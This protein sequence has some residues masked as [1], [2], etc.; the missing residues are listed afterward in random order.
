M[1][2]PIS[3][4][5]AESNQ[6]NLDADCWESLRC[7]INAEAY[8]EERDEVILPNHAQCMSRI[9]FYN[10]NSE[11]KDGRLPARMEKF[12]SSLLKQSKFFTKLGEELRAYDERHRIWRRY[13]DEKDRDMDVVALGDELTISEC[14]RCASESG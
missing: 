13:R 6:G 4:V 12:K 1:M 11:K 9:R 7:L 8:F 3:K 5:E 2:P 10:V 14:E